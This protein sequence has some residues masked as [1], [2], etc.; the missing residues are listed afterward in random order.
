MTEDGGFSTLNLE[1][2]LDESIKQFQVSYYGIIILTSLNRVLLS[3]FDEYQTFHNDAS[4]K[5]SILNELDGKS[6][7]KQVAIHHDHGLILMEN[8]NIF[9]FGSYLTIRQDQTSDLIPLPLS[10]LKSNEIVVQCYLGFR[11]TFLL[12]SEDRLFSFGDNRNYV[13][14]DGTKVDR[15]FPV[16]ITKYFK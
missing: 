3:I 12:T 9:M 4:L 15:E 7:V 6:T 1:L 2:F 16:E 5:F 13:L 10:F 11:R 8:G 14:G